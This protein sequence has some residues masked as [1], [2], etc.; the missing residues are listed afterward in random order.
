MKKTYQEK[1]K[2]IFISIII[3]YDINKFD[4]NIYKMFLYIVT[5][6]Q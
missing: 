6:Q 1:N 2:A 3:N 5:H 4:K